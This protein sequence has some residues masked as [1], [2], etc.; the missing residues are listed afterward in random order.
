MDKAARWLKRSLGYEF[1]DPALLRR[2][3]THR[4]AAGPNNERLEF[5][6]DAVLEF[7]VSDLVFALHPDAAE[8][9]LSRLRASLVRDTTLAELAAEIALGD[10]LV[11][12]SGE[13]KS[14]GHRRASILADAIEAIFGA[15]YLDS[16]FDAAKTV[17]RR[18]LSARAAELPEPDALKDSKTLLQEWLQADG[19]GLPDYATVEVSGKAHEQVFDVSCTIAALGLVT[20]GR[21]TSRRDAEQ[22]AATNMLKQ[23]E[24]V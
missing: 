17:I 19:H 10:H 24:G 13:K 16:G 20:H 1:Q 7:V 12:G 15:I 14:G 9:E 3:L 2:A 18:V 21:G 4:S 11:L 23:L 22:D 8:G 6:G 5:L